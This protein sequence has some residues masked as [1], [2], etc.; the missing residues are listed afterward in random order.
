MELYIKRLTQLETIAREHSG[1]TEAYAVQAG[2]EVR[3]IVDARTADD[4][5]THRIAAA[6]AQ[7][8]EQEMTFPGEI[9]VSVLREVRADAVAR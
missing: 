8:V 9:K 1:V 3:V 2:R 7:R 6:I 4:A 5:A